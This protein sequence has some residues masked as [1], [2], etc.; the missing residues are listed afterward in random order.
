M[1]SV[2]KKY[3]LTVAVCLLGIGQGFGANNKCATGTQW[4]GFT[5]EIAS[6]PVGSD[7]YE[8]DTPEKLAWF[9]C[10]TTKEKGAQYSIKAKLTQSIDL[11]HKLFFPIA[12][13]PGDNGNAGFKGEFDGQGFK[14]SNLYM[15]SSEMVKTEF[16][17]QKNYAQ[18]IGFV[19]VLGGGTVKNLILENVDIQASTSAGEANDN[20]DSQISVGA[21]VGWM[22]PMD[23]NVVDGCTVSG[24]IKTTGNGQGVGGIVGNAKTGTISNCMSLVEI[25]T[26]GS[27][28]YIGGVIGITKTDVTVSSCV[29][30]GPGLTNTGD[31]GLVGGIAGNVFTGKLT[32]ENDYYEG[33]NINGIG[34]T[35][36]KSTKNECTT[37]NAQ[38]AAA[39]IANADAQNVDATNAENYVC[40]LNGGKWNESESICENSTSD[41]WSVGETGL[42]L[43][44]YGKDGYKITFDANRGIFADGSVAKNKF[45]EMGLAITA[46]EIGNPSRDYY[47]FIGWAFT[48]DAT[49]PENLGFVSQRE[50]VYAVWE[51]KI[52]VTFDANGGA[53]PDDS[54]TKDVYI[55]KNSPI[56]VDGLGS[57]PG[58]Y[59]KQYSQTDATQ[60]V[61]TMYFTGW[62]NVAGDKID[63]N[64]HDVLATEDVKY[65]AEWTDVE[66]YS[67]TFH[68]DDNTTVD[69]VQWVDAGHTVAKPSDPEMEGYTFLAWY[70]GNAPFDFKTEI[71]ASKDLY[72]HW[73]PKQYDISYN[74][75][76]GCSDKGDNPEN[77]I[78]GEG[79][80]TLNPPTT[81]E[82]YVFDD[83]FYDSGFTNRATALDRD[84]VGDKAFFAKCSKKTY[85]IIYM[86]D[87][88]SYGSTS[89][90]YVEHGASITLASEGI[91]WR[92][93]Y[94]QDGW[95]RDIGGDRDYV[96][97]K[98]YTITE[99]LTLY[100]HWVTNLEIT[101][102]G[103]VRIYDY[104]DHKEAVIDGN[105]GSA[106]ATDEV[107]I[108]NDVEVTK[109]TLNRKF[110]KGI[111][112][113]IMLPFSINLDNISGGKFYRFKRVDIVNGERKIII[114]SVKT[115][116]V[117]A[118]TPYMFL[119][120]AEEITFTGSVTLNTETEPSETLVTED[121]S[122]EFKGT[123]KY[124]QFD[125][126]DESI[127]GFAG[128]ARSGAK[129]G[130][131]VQN[132]G[133][134]AKILA[135]RA[136]L[137]DC[138]HKT[139]DYARSFNGAVKRSQLSSDIIDV[140]IEDE[141]GG[142][143][144]IGKFNTITG[145]VRIDRWFDLKGRRLNAKPTVQGTYYHN[146]KRVIVK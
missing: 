118:N 103:A 8:I 26:S 80:L 21:V 134:G 69:F 79:L 106:D 93:G 109:V 62:M 44:G 125:G 138:V 57:L 30:A 144:A 14:I 71:R 20:K 65:N 105:Y 76:E 117:G 122:W 15:S 78:L 74:L 70:D 126:S 50:T 111:M 10:E 77:F 119:P 22:A 17:G 108:P 87:N 90:Q 86:A 53:F 38:S 68:S 145:E 33:E 72:A 127:F 16:G 128:Q 88:N 124:I 104:G 43:N 41:Y 67:V 139:R 24:T 97:G 101:S 85:K 23:G 143:T 64:N 110:D 54:E 55:S 94:K 56:T 2:A 137:I 100:P 92:T 114:G 9:A 47:T 52:K 75:S 7:Y 141:D 42:S 35:I 40:V 27:D 4:G 89:D 116:S 96:F 91:F 81:Q 95:S 113:T 107:Q 123:Y 25:Q 28:A 112:S 66:T 48:Q 131:F 32:T 146:G 99:D 140:E 63:F 18:N 31:N 1:F 3:V 36:C 12:A 59:C 132:G 6:K 11:K 58:S 37:A 60:C 29:Y 135:M 45:L 34:G 73:S 133:S 83:W 120:E 98:V 61:S 46:D 49:E 84:V 51:E 5:T 39:S 82:G 121:G 136:Y 13:G 19:A 102:I 115:S 142:V 129:V 130:Q